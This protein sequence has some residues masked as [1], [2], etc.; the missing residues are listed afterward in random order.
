[1]LESR[2]TRS[3]PADGVAPT[4]RSS[5]LPDVHP[6]PRTG[7][8]FV[9]STAFSS[10]LVVSR[11]ISNRWPGV[12]VTPPLWSAVSRS[13]SVLRLL[14]LLVP[15][16]LLQACSDSGG[17]GGPSAPEEPGEERAEVRFATRFAPITGRSAQDPIA[18]MRLTV[19]EVE[20][21]SV[22]AGPVVRGSGPDAPG[23]EVRIDLSVPDGGATVRVLVEFLDASGQTEWS[24]LTD[25][26]G[27]GPGDTVHAPDADVHPGPPGN[28]SADSVRILTPSD[29][30]LARSVREGGTVRIR[31]R[32][33]GGVR[34]ST[35]VVWSTMLPEIAGVDEEGVV[36]ARAPD[37]ARIEAIA[38]PVRDTLVLVVQGRIHALRIEPAE[39]VLTRA[40]E[41]VQMRATAFDAHGDTVPPGTI[42]W[43]S[44][45]E[46]IAVHRGSGVFEA[47][48]E[49]VAEIT[50]AGET[51][52]EVGGAALL[53]VAVPDVRPVELVLPPFGSGLPEH[54]PVSIG[55]RVV[56]EGG[57]AAPATTLALGV[58]NADREG[59]VRPDTLLPVRALDPD[60]ESVVRVELPAPG[61]GV[62][63]PSVRF[64][65][66]ADPG[67]SIAEL[68]EDDNVLESSAV[69][70]LR[71]VVSV[72]VRPGADTVI[73][74]GD[75]ARFSATL[76]D[77]FGEPVERPV[78]WR[79]LQPDVATVDTGGGVAAESRGRASITATSGGAADTAIF[80][81]LGRPDLLPEA[82]EVTS[83]TPD[84]VV[85]DE[86]FRVVLRARNAGGSSSPA[87]TAVLRAVDADGSAVL[88]ESVLDVPA[89]AAGASME[90]EASLTAAPGDGWSDRVR[91]EATLD[92]EARVA[93]ADERNNTRASGTLTVRRAPIG[94]RIAPAADTVE[95]PG[96]T[97]RFRAVVTDAEGGELDVEVEWRSLDPDV[98]GVD[99]AGLATAAAEGGARIVAA[100]AGLADTVVLVVTGADGEPPPPP[101]DLPDL[102]PTRLDPGLEG[103]TIV[104]GEPVEL[105]VEIT[106]EGAAP[107][108]GTVLAVRVLDTG[109]GEPV[110]DTLVGV[111]SVPSGGSALVTLALAT[112]AVDDWPDAVVL[113]AE[114]DADDAL[115]EEDETDNVARS[116]TLALRRAPSRLEV[117]PAADT[118]EAP[119]DT[120]RFR[121]VV[122]DAEGGELDVEVEWRSLDPDVAGVDRAGLATA[123]AEGD[124][125]IEA[126]SAGLADT[127]VL[128]VAGTDG[129]PPPPPADLPDLRVSELAPELADG[130]SIREGG[131]VTVTGTVRNDG[132][133]EAPASRLLLRFLDGALE[134]EV[135]DTVVETPALP[136]GGAAP[137]RVRYA[138]DDAS[139]WPDR[140]GFGA[141]ADA[142]DAIEESD[143]VNN[144]RVAP[145]AFPLRRAVAAVVVSPPADTLPAPG[146]TATFAA[147]LLAS[148]GSALDRPVAW[149]ADDPA[150]AT[151]DGTGR[152][153]AVGRGTTLLTAT[154]EGV[155]GQATVVVTSPDLAFERLAVHTT[156]DG[157]APRGDTARV[158]VRIRNVGDGPAASTTYVLRILDAATLE[159]VAGQDTTLVVPALGPGEAFDA[160][161]ALV[162]DP[163]GSW[164]DVVRFEGEAD[165]DGLL[166]D[167]D[168]DDNVARSEELEVVEAV[169]VGCRLSP[170]GPAPSGVTPPVDRRRGC[171]NN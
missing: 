27:I 166:P 99:R 169:P 87:T 163:D 160:V 120:A 97:A 26:V 130:D 147:E 89:L 105:T 114:V 168:R 76:A 69:T 10:V 119:G 68:D 139:A 83:P 51:E 115:E 144:E 149:E 61:A 122:T 113:E 65:A 103:D 84:T 56:N 41:R 138:V 7:R 50:A 1:M 91:I 108:G 4:A 59:E 101:A 112:D 88:H 42:R 19:L 117:A 85:E 126:A 24:G 66:T 171:R 148:D 104:E 100:S 70:I 81:V 164:P 18:R 20:T 118:V 53:T 127:V 28:L 129:E 63:P 136:A 141:R 109:S 131:T 33:F 29:T 135:A 30:L 38:G 74:P 79:S 9:D 60:E 31:A 17:G 98:A 96:D 142:D 14:L 145:A 6:G 22:V 46:G 25:P 21:R 23:R 75:T 90:L 158:D 133:A 16:L 37:D 156:E 159:T 8:R 165:P 40:S 152:V 86:P 49:G 162:V 161:H 116:R 80:V 123:A 102:R 121:A 11:A 143:E 134:T 71:A 32:V 92:P 77:A 43:A 167:P 36:S 93:E 73:A 34:D 52:P 64:R 170:Q 5:P 150:V 35:R 128:V 110:R 111:S 95:A 157:S 2:G 137:F 12:A 155:S 45:D 54:E 67:D 47:V 55:M 58:R 72:S 132:E 82:L 57:S 94:I 39:P 3:V 44:D 153:T 151:V 106:N 62:W 13:P 107:A 146:E 78:R 15:G 125:R 140:I 154:S 48:G 124:A